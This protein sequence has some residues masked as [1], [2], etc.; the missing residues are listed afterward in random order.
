MVRS[1]ISHILVL[2]DGTQSSFRAAD[3]AIDI[4]RILGARLTALAVVDTDTLHQLLSVNILVDI[5]L[6]EFEK[7]LAH[8]AQHQLD[9]VR[10]HAMDK[11]V[12]L[13]EVLRS[14]NSEVIVPIEL[15]QRG[16]DL[17]AMGAFQSERVKHDLLARQRQQILDHA[18]CPIL[19]VK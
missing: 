2:V 8:S 7:E 3:Y 1:P 6:A 14:G 18:Q 11:R 4:A 15:S 19:I 5:E 12:V 16:I 9:E 17:L 10:H 13:D